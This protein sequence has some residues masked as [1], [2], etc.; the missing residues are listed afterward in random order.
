M[1][2]REPYSARQGSITVP[3]AASSGDAAVLPGIHVSLAVAAHPANHRVLPIP[4]TSGVYL[5]RQKPRRRDCL[6][7]AVTNTC[8]TGSDPE[9]PSGRVASELLGA[10]PRPFGAVIYF[11]QHPRTGVNLCR[12]AYGRIIR[13][14]RPAASDHPLA[15]DC[16]V[17]TI[18]FVDRCNGSA[19]ST[20]PRL[21]A[22]SR[23]LGPV[24]CGRASYFIHAETS[25]GLP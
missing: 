15:K 2:I 14:P 20:T 16:S 4:H 11:H 22:W 13:Q 3:C 8:T 7:Q 9:R 25:P 10:R 18:G 23:W 6:G 21:N 1:N 5:L 24:C 12:A 19:C 17:P